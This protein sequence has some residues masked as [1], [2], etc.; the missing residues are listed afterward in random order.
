M[1]RE[2]K[3]EQIWTYICSHDVVNARDVSLNTGISADLVNVNLSRFANR[4]WLTYVSGKGVSGDPKCYRKTHQARPEFKGHTRDKSQSRYSKSDRQ[5]LW[6]NMKISRKFTVTD[7]LSSIDVPVRVAERFITVLHKAG[8]VSPF[9]VRGAQVKR[10]N[11]GYE[12]VWVL[13]RDTGRLAPKGR[14]SGL[15]D[16]NEKK[17]YRF[18]TLDEA[19]NQSKVSSKKEINQ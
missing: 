11:N 5:M 7:L 2:Y 19:N 1:A 4:G 10:L 16:Q 17:F 9:T 6:N 15:W 8:Y 14:K 13:T 12:P 3:C 18:Q